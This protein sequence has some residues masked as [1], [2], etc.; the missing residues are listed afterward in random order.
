MSGI[1]QARGRYVMFLDSDD[2]LD[3]NA[4][5]NLVTAA[6]ESG[7][8][9]VS[10]RC[11]RVLPEREQN[12]YPSLYRESRV[13][14][15]IRDDPELLYDTLSTNKCYR[16]DFL[17][18]EELR[19]VD[20]LHY[21][22]LLFSAQAY[23]A[24]RKIAIIPHRVYNWL[25]IPRGA[26]LSITN[27]RAELRNFADRLEIHRRI[28]ATFHKHGAAELAKLKNVK[29]VNHDLLLYLRE[30]RSRDPEYRAAFLDLAR[31]Y[32][33]TMDTAVFEECKRMTA[34]AGFMILQGDLDAAMAAA[35]H[36]PRKCG[37]P[38]LS[39]SLSSARAGCTGRAPSSTPS[40]AVAPLT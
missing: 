35:D 8:E 40:R 32:L 36:S 38:T 22:D 29:F 13:L 6:E 5:R 11:V 10:G 37:T 25:V 33:A 14:A 1:E 28:D 30:L 26:T 7:A 2:T 21:E 24:A 17:E 23:V 19:F 18:R 9:L 27:R 12:W 31:S 34:I 15:G 39:S 3:P 4:C 20:R 16:R